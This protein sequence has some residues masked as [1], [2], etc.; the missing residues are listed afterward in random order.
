[1]RQLVPLF[2]QLVRA[3]VVSTPV[4]QCLLCRRHVDVLANFES[5]FSDSKRRHYVLLHVI[6]GGGDLTLQRGKETA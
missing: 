1:M 2:Y 6:C 3:S 4:F 5:D